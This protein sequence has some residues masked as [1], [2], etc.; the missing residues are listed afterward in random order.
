MRVGGGAEGEDEGGG[1]VDGRMG[2]RGRRRRREAGPLGFV[3]VGGATRL[4]ATR[5]RVHISRTDKVGV[6]TCVHVC[7]C[8][9]VCMCVCVCVC[10]DVM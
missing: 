10:V 9:C 1:A 5:E 3:A 7:V 4:L 2:G 6:R 8:V